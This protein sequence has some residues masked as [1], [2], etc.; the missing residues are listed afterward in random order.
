MERENTAHFREYI[1]IIVYIN[2]NNINS[3]YCW[4]NE[5]NKQ[6]IKDKGFVDKTHWQSLP[7]KISTLESPVMKIC[8][9]L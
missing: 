1:N 2:I 3:K 4:Y 6:F 7:A 5:A 9:C 8:V